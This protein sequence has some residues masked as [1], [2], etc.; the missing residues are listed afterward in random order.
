MERTIAWLNRCRRLSRDW[1]CLNRNARAFLR[2]ASVRMML[3]RLC[4]HTS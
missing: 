1:E 4:N 2:R 3:R